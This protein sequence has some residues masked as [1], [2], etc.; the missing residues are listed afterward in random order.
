MASR[1]CRARVL[2]S[3]VVNVIVFVE[4]V[5]TAQT[6]LKVHFLNAVAVTL[7][8][9]QAPTITGGETIPTV[10]VLPIPAT[11][12]GW[13]EGHLTLTLSVEAPGDFSTY[14]LTIFGSGL[15]PFFDWI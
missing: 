4:F 12:W 2:A 8:P 5:N 7:S 9:A 6:V 11:A 15:D 14:T 13:D 1:D 10:T 3:T